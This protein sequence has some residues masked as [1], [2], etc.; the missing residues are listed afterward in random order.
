MALVRLIYLGFWE[1]F[2]P[3]IFIYLY[4][5]LHIFH[6]FILCICKRP[7]KDF[8]VKVVM[9]VGVDF[10]ALLTVGL[11]LSEL[12]HLCRVVEQTV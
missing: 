6:F 5:F 4:T 8:V 10:M 12:T 9:F 11:S 2:G 3:P 1:K 7:H